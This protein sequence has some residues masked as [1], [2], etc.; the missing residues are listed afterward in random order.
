[1]S[2]FFCVF[3]VFVLYLIVKTIVKNVKLQR[4]RK[5]IEML[6]FLV[7]PLI[8]MNMLVLPRL[9]ENMGRRRSHFYWEIWNMKI[10][11]F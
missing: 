5:K 2:N 8:L 9:L 4:F 6:R 7:V 10:T 1:M 3:S 11:N